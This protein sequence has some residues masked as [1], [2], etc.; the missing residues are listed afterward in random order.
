MTS[1]ALIVALLAAMGLFF[2]VLAGAR[3]R[4]R[5]LLAAT[6]S[7]FGGCFCLALAAVA[8]AFAFN[9]YTYHRLTY[10]QPVAQLSFERLAA[11]RYRV[12]LGADSGRARQFDLN[13]DQWQVDARVLK[14]HPLGN[15][16]GLDAV[17]RLDR[18]SGRYRQIE[19]AN[20][21]PRTVYDL[22]ESRGLDV[23]QAAKKLPDWLQI[24][25]AE[26]GSATYLPMADGAEFSVS[27][28]QSGLVARP[29][30]EA[31]RAAIRNW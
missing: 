29:E 14:W 8:A 24:V 18:V 15:L 4:R 1:P 25:D 30:N 22:S 21:R 2:V 7:G 17:Y 31:A 6:R 19:A 13:G 10:E 5:R 3:I 23:W 12:S 27:L 9:L 20:A 11:Q 26:Y 28:S 16:L